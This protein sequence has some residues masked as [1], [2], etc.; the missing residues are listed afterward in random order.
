MKKPV[1]SPIAKLLK[2]K[3]FDIP[4]RNYYLLKE[5][6]KFLHE[7]FDDEYWGDNRIVNWND[8]I[9][10]IKPF[11]GFISAPTIA[12]VLMWLYE[13]HK[14]WISVDAPHK[15]LK[16]WCFEAYK[17]NDEITL[18]EKSLFNSPTEAYEAAIDY[19]LNNLI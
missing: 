6:G 4:V 19:V 10:P 14:I 9:S 7:G 3:G 12:E 18:I 2:E 16:S 17:I 13:K 8:G 11:Q 5:K 1:S 15:L